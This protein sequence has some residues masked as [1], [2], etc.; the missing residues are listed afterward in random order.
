MKNIYKLLFVSLLVFSVSCSDSENTIDEILNA[1]QGAILRT[2]SVDNAVLNSSD[3]NSA[4][5]ATVEEQDEADG[6]LLS[7]IRVNATFRDLSPDSLQR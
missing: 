6:A 2:I 1:E 7:E 3:P 5:V 4:F